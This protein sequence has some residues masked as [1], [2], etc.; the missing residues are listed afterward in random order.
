M[1]PPR[2]FII[3]FNEKEGSTPLV[4]ILDNFANV[5]V[6]HVDDEQGWEPFDAHN[7]GPIAP[8]DFGRC[9]DLVWGEAGADRMDRLNAIYT[10]TGRMPLAAFDAANARGFKMRFRPQREP[11][12]GWLARRRG[13][14]RFERTFFTALTRHRVVA[15]FAVRQDLL[16]WAL[17]KYHGD[18][19]G[20][21][22]HIQ[23]D[24]ARNRVARAELKPIHV[25][26][27]AFARL[28][29][30]CRAIIAEKRSLARRMARRGVPVHVLSYERFCRDRTGLYADLL[31]TIDAPATPSDMETAFAR[32][33][34]LKKVHDDDIRG[35]V[36][37]ADALLARF[38]EPFETW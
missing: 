37:N 16:R 17:S 12:G 10:T 30:D 21:P 35:F 24:L 34:P 26:L 27:D 15:F 14:A 1:P 38:G 22:G 3:L 31:A 19:R 29:D 28:L 13:V 7:C 32:G 6:L 18:G 4:Q 5:D 2:N 25:D 36:E 11:T 33:T 23:F 20:R 8:K 9:L